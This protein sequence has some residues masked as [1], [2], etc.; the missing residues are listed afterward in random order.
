MFNYKYKQIMKNLM[1]SLAFMLVGSFASEASSLPIMNLHYSD[2]CITSN[3][4]LSGNSIADSQIDLLL[5]KDEFLKS[6]GT[7]EAK[8]CVYKMYNSEGTFLGFW[9]VMVPDYVSCGSKKAKDLAI[10]DYNV[11]H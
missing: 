10:A 6:E 2:L 11:F 9:S 4:I 5:L 7:V 3:D 8:E 1:F